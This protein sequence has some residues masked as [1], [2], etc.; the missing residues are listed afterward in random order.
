MG[1]APLA[2]MSTR[3]STGSTPVKR[4]I[5]PS[6][7]S[8][9]DPD[10][11]GSSRSKRPKKTESVAPDGVEPDSGGSGQ[12]RRPRRSE[13]EEGETSRSTATRPSAPVRRIQPPTMKSSMKELVGSWNRSARIWK[14][15]ET[16]R[17]WL[18]KTKK[19]HNEQ[20]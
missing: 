11:G 10:S 14:Q 7:S 20:N 19:R 9:N 3:S 8:D 15:S 12:S 16:T 6:F 18:R 13:P 17:G 4:P 5:L 2:S 1:G